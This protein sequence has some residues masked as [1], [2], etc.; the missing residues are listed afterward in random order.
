MPL[1]ACGAVSCSSLL[2]FSRAISSPSG[3]VS[4]LIGLVSF[5]APALYVHLGR[6]VD[7]AA[8]DGKRTPYVPT[9]EDVRHREQLQNLRLTQA[10]QQDNIRTWEHFLGTSAVT[11]LALGLAFGNKRKVNGDA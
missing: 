7:Y 9:V 5:A 3:A 11:A 10:L 2:Q 6:I 1:S 8:L 4:T